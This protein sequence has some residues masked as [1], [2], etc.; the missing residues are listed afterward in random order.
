MV[1]IFNGIL[2]QHLKLCSQGKFSKVCMASHNIILTG[3]STGN[4]AAKDCLS[5]GI[6]KKLEVNFCF[7]SLSIY[8]KFSK[9]SKHFSQY[10]KKINIINMELRTTT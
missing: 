8:S 5:L 3:Q 10:Q 4:C 9:I 6:E 1:S 7:F 2:C